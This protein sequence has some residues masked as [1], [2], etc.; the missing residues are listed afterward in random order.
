MV[1]VPRA[2]ML[3]QKAAFINIDPQDTQFWPHASYD[4]YGYMYKYIKLRY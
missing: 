3:P 1:V 4:I 2:T